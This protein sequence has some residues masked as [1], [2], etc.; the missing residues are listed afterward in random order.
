MKISKGNLIKKFYVDVLIFIFLLILIVLL[1]DKLSVKLILIGVLWLLGILKIFNEMK[2]SRELKILSESP[3]FQEDVEQKNSSESINMNNDY[4]DS[5]KMYDNSRDTDV[6]HENKDNNAKEVNNVHTNNSF[7]NINTSKNRFSRTVQ[8]IVLINEEG[9]PLE[10]WE[11]FGKIS[12]MIG[13]E[14][15]EHDIDIDL[16]KS[17]YASFIDYQHAI[18]NYYNNAWHIEDYYSDNG[19]CIQ[20]KF[21]AKIYEISPREACKVDVGDT[22]YIANT[23]LLVV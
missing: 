12:L 9:T 16:S 23:K 14:N 11:I 4:E 8:G 21:K 2:F 19:V 6:Q 5:L 7:N 15:K 13:K 22:I 17:A 1:I 18:L 3:S 10:E 20:K